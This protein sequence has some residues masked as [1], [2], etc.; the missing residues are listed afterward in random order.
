MLAGRRPENVSRLLLGALRLR[1]EIPET[2]S[3]TANVLGLRQ[4]F[5]MAGRVL[6]EAGQPLA[7]GPTGRPYVISFI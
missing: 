5:F 1:R 3:E 7:S 2:L 6:G 4:K